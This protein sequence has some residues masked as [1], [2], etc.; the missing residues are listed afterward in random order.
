MCDLEI[1]KW[2]P[3]K[4]HNLRVDAN[5]VACPFNKAVADLKNIKNKDKNI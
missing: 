5:I 3:L 2:P 1:N 4:M